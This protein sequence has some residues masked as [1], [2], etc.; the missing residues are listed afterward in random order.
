MPSI[1]LTAFLTAL[2]GGVPAY[3]ADPPASALA[4]SDARSPDAPAFVLLGVSPS[5]IER[6]TTPRALGISLLS[7]A[8]DSDNLIPQNYALSVAPYWL[9]GHPALS[10]RE[11]YNPSLR[12]SVVDTLSF[13]V[14]SS[15]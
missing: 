11:Y 7:T 8:L 15:R 13:S 12:Q 5:Q 4:V 2:S 10:N 9:A 3:G 14:V 6:P 1:A